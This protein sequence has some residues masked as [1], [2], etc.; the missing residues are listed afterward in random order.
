MASSTST[1]EL[2]NTAAYQDK[3]IG[4]LGGRDPI[5]VLGKTPDAMDRFVADNDAA[6]LRAR[7]FPGKWTPL[8]IIGHLI[9]A[10]YLFAYRVRLILCEN[11]PVIQSMDQELWVTGQRY[12]ERDPVELAADF[13]A[14]RKINVGLW[15]SMRPEDLK[16]FGRHA[17]RG[18]ESL[19][20]MLLM[21]AGH[22]L[23]HIDQ[24]TRYLAAIRER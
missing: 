3:L 10:E 1:V 23:S 4:Q 6:T 14:L 2:G 20:T 24:I 15:R 5:E 12:N 13:R 16:K 18:D 17:E 19:Q 22:D 21:H 11:S 8:E 7:P 9:D